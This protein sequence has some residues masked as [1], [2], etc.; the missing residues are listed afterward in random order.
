MS[1]PLP[2]PHK[3]SE[4]G[5]YESYAGFSKTLRG[6]LVAYGIGA[7]VLFA[8]QTSFAKVL[9]NAKIARPIIICFLI[10]VTLQ[11]ALSVVYKYC[12]FHLYLGEIDEKYKLYR[13]HRIADWFASQ[14]WL[15]LIIDV[16][17]ILLFSYAT[18]WLLFAALK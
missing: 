13:I 7:P 10:G 18:T 5:F 15:E 14:T 3:P 11:I 12:M 4:S 1:V 6:W 2:T 17:T 16:V 8:S 9:A